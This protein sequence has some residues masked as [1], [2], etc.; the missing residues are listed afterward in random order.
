MVKVND[1]T[2][3]GTTEG[4]Y[5]ITFAPAVS[6]DTISRFLIQKYV[7][8]RGRAGSRLSREEGKDI[9]ARMNLRDGTPINRFVS[10]RG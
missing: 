2:N 9:S 4:S 1:G 3:V 5:E 6:R 10:F 8:D 7:S